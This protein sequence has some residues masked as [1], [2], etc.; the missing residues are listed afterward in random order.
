[1]TMHSFGCRGCEGL[2]VQEFETELSFHIACMDL[3][4]AVLEST[5]IPFY[6]VFENVLMTT[7]GWIACIKRQ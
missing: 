5:D 3:S 7:C 6:D 1:M 2:E 4:C